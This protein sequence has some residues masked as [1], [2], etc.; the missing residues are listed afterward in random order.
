MQ[1][2]GLLTLYLGQN[3]SGQVSSKWEQP[4]PLA[5]QNTCSATSREAKEVGHFPKKL[6]RLWA[7]QAVT[8]LA[9]QPTCLTS[10]KSF[11]SAIVSRGKKKEEKKVTS[12]KELFS[13]KYV[14]VEKLW[15]GQ[16]A[17][18]SVV[19]KQSPLPEAWNHHKILLMPKGRYTLE[20]R[21][22]MLKDYLVR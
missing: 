5:S 1:N 3:T 11:Q 10:A 17:I 6:A 7:C 19:L 20:I 15:P 13:G 8:P 12:E 21:Y 16:E 2:S 18:L 14:L 4:S 9:R 22:V